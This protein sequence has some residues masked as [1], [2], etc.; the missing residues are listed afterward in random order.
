MCGGT[1]YL[2]KNLKRHNDSVLGA[3]L[4]NNV[5]SNAS[6]LEP[7]KLHNGTPHRPVQWYNV[8]ASLF[9]FL[10]AL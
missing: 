3:N 8:K 5:S 6:H 4:S 9:C 2:K 10:T 1:G 7:Q